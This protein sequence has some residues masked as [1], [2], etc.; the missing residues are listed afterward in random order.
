MTNIR[1]GI[2]GAALLL[3][4]GLL[5]S[6]TAEAGAGCGCDQNLDEDYAVSADLA[7]TCDAAAAAVPATTG[8]DKM[9]A[10]GTKAKCPVSGKEFEVTKDTPFSVYKGKYYVFCCPGCKPQFDKNPASFLK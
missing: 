4:F 5:A 7:G 9:P 3:G 8:Y 6:R 2:I 10:V 1:Y